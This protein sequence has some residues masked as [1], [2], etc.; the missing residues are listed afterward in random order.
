MKSNVMH[1]KL[2]SVAILYL[3]ISSIFLKSS[4]QLTEQDIYKSFEGY[5]LVKKYEGKNPG[6][7]FPKTYDPSKLS[8]PDF[9]SSGPLINLVLFIF[10]PSLL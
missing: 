5:D 8:C 10:I 4:N 9:D 6:K 7:S 1:M 3:G 2:I